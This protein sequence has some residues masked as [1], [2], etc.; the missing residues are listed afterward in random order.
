[1]IVTITAAI[2][3]SDKTNPLDLY[4][5]FR[6]GTLEGSPHLILTDPIYSESDRE[7]KAVNDWLNKQEQRV[8]QLC[9]EILGNGIIQ[10]S[11]RN[12]LVPPARLRIETVNQPVWDKT[13]KRHILPL[14][15]AVKFL[16]SPFTI[17]VENRRNDKAFLEAIATGWRRERLQ[18]LLANHFIEFNGG[19]GIGE[20]KKWVEEIADVSAKR[21]RSF[22]LFDSDAPQPQQPSQQSQEVVETC[23][24]T[25]IPYHQLQR[26][27]IENYLS[28]ESL[29]MW[30]TGKVHESVHGKNKH[31]LVEEFKNLTNA[32][33]YHLDMKKHFVS[34]IADLF[35]TEYPKIQES[36]LRKDADLI[37]EINPVLDKLFSLV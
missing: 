36:R 34:N 6:L 21:H 35:K 37:Q 23:Q 31:Q 17:L 33:R 25:A 18:K 22:A 4:A 10:Y 32:Q 29:A 11:E 28:L 7:A 8:S 24:K 16:S 12:P 26:R 3:S 14:D 2:F 15:K 19:G 1:M 30:A 5:L 9:R 20:V 27:A 13:N